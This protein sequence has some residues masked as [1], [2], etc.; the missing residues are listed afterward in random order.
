MDSPL[1]ADWPRDVAPPKAL[2]SNH[3]RIRA[4]SQAWG[5]QRSRDRRLGAAA[6]PGGSSSDIDLDPGMGSPAAL[7]GRWKGAPVTETPVPLP[8]FPRLPA[9]TSPR[10]PPLLVLPLL[11]PLLLVPPPRMLPP[12]PLPRP[13]P[14]T[15]PSPPR[16][17]PP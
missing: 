15:A 14:R 7:Q 17:P 3:Y 8:E 4:L 1:D 2:L 12:R 6:K 16:T 11:V 10:P 13:C 9:R 5:E